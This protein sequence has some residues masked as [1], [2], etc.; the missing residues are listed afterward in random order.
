MRISP[1]MLIVLCGLLALGLAGV[2]L[3]NSAVDSDAP[4]M[5]ASPS[6]IVLAKVTTLTVH[7]N[8]VA[9]TVDAGSLDLDGAVPTGV[10][11][12]NCGHIVAK[13]AVA[14]LGLQPGQATL[15]LSGSF[16]DGGTFSASDVVVV[17]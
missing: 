13:F 15:T 9:S 11:V 4:A 12:D 14:D 8:I 16:T 5:M 1:I 10:G 3:A 6:T 17:K 2:V 7:T